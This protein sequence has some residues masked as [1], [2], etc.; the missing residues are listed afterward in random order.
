MAKAARAKTKKSRGPKANGGAGTRPGARTKKGGAAGAKTVANSRSVEAFLRKAGPVQLRD[1][2]KLV[3]LMSRVTGAPPQ[4]WGSNIVGFGSYRYVYATGRSGDWPL[5]AFSPRPRELTVYIM[6]GF[7]GQ[8]ELLERLGR[9]RTGKSCL[10]LKGLEG[11]D[12]RALGELVEGSVRAMR[13]R[14]PDPPRR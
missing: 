1:C 4:M 10:Y 9:P 6:P 3:A 12:E 5:V 8:E 2:R 14:Y 7:E 13:E 11:V